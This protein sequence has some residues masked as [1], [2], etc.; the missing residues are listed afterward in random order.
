MNAA[1]VTLRQMLETQFKRR[2][3]MTK[4]V[5]ALG[6]VAVALTAM[7]AQAQHITGPVTCAHRHHGRC[8]AWRPRSVGYVFGP[9]YA[10]TDYSALP[11]P[12]VTRYHLRH[13]Y[14]YVSENGYVYVVNPRTYRVVR[15][16]SPL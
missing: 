14:R 2:R 8:E 9:S 7:P 5:L 3:S 15:V 11:V 6:G 4:L 13:N 1:T 16:I 12:I 10:Y